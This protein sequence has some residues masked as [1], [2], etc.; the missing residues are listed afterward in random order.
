MKYFDYKLVLFAGYDYSPKTKEK[1]RN[2][3]P[4]K[5]NKISQLQ[6]IQTI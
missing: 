6:T 5:K 4:K 1:L 2:R 3:K